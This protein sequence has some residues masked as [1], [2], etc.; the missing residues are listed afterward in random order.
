M[1]S[2]LW[3]WEDER[4]T[5][6]GLRLS[7][8]DLARDRAQYVYEGKP[9]NQPG[10]ARDP[11]RIHQ[12]AMLQAITFMETRW[13][14]P[15]L[16]GIHED[17]IGL[18]TLTVVEA[19][20]GDQTVDFYFDN[21]THLPERIL[22]RGPGPDWHEQYDLSDYRTVDGVQLPLVVAERNPGFGGPF[23]RRITYRLNVDYDSAIFDRPPSLER[24]PQGWQRAAGGTR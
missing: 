4:P 21:K 13:L 14:K 2:Q 15:A 9:P 24:G 12:V 3:E 7:I 10:T 23:T 5:K 22:F 8:A 17:R 19:G 11:A 1:P 6:F 20:I 16:T 18:R